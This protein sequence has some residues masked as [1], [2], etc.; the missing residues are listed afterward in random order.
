MKIDACYRPGNWKP[1]TGNL[2]FALD[3]QNRFFKYPQHRP[4]KR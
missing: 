4:G 2:T 1:E 3:E